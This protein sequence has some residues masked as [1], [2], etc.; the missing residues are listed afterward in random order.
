MA[1]STFGIQ[2]ED[3]DSLASVNLNLQHCIPDEEYAI[4]SPSRRLGGHICSETNRGDA[5][6][7][8]P[9]LTS[10]HVEHRNDSSML[11]SQPRS[12]M[13]SED[14]P[15]SVLSVLKTTIMER[16]LTAISRA[17]SVRKRRLVETLPS[18]AAVST[19][20]RN[21]ILDL[22]RKRRGI[23]NSS[24]LSTS[25]SESDIRSKSVLEKMLF[26]CACVHISS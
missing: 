2:I 24:S 4:R 17:L 6:L 13:L 21:R 16:P 22:V 15:R 25:S 20:V 12:T 7:H 18:M 9:G 19:N 3:C 1:S 11:G 5:T 26:V 10:K 14:R 23:G 8:V